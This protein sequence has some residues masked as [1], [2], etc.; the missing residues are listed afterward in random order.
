MSCDDDAERVT[1]IAAR[2]SSG[3]VRSLHGA[4]AAR[5]RQLI[6]AKSPSNRGKWTRTGKRV[7]RMLDKAAGNGPTGRKR[8]RA[9][10]YHQAYSEAKGLQCH[11]PVLIVSS[12]R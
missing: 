4:T 10:H 11:D 6:A 2:R 3:W 5:T 1:T 12:I 8:S 9:H 7:L